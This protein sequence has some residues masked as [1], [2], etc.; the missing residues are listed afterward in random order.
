[1]VLSVALFEF[2]F[3]FDSDLLLL[4]PLL[5]LFDSELLPELLLSLSSSEFDFEPDSDSELFFDLDFSF[6][7]SFASLSFFLSF[8]ESRTEELLMFELLLKRGGLLFLEL[9]F[10]ELFFLSSDWTFEL[11]S[12]L[13]ILELSFSLINEDLKEL[14]LLE[15]LE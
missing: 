1:M 2:D 5:E 6:D 12:L 15:P 14:P 3:E 10:F 11:F 8:F 7:F 4:S 13:E 9:D